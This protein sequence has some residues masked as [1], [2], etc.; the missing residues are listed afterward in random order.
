MKIIHELFRIN[1]LQI[2]NKNAVI[3]VSDIL[4]DQLK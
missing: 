3:N 1:E 4:N 2:R